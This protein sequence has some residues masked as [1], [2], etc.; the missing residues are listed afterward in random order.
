MDQWSNHWQPAGTYG[1]RSPNYP[2]QPYPPY[3]VSPNTRYF[4]PAGWPQALP[5]DS[6]SGPRKSHL[7]A[8]SYRNQSFHLALRRAPKYPT[9]NPILAADN[10][11]IRFDLRQ[12]P[13]ADILAH[14][15]YTYRSQLATAVPCTHL[16]IISKQ[17]PWSVD[18]KTSTQGPVTC[19]MVWEA[20]YNALQVPLADS[21]WGMVACGDKKLRE[22]ID[23]AVKLRLE[24]EKDQG[25]EG[26]KSVKRIDWLG[27]V[28]IFNGLERS[29][30]FEKGRLMPG[31][32]ECKETWIVRL[33][34]AS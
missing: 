5:N 9:I 7:T 32:K 18:I 15:Y 6:I 31:A 33:S 30:E 20:L 19:E 23:K 4:Q 29:E 11:V 14:T 2:A 8:Y 16:R 27:E 34:C 13:N 25:K 1:P 26:N 22:G 10:T 12:K 3:D 24:W 21:E 17:F 28:T